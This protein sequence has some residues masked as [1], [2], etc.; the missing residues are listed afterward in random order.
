ML[1][2]SVPRLLSLLFFLL[3]TVVHTWPMASNPGTL[4]RN[5]N[6]DA[7]LNEWILAWVAHA[8]RTDPTALFHPPIFFPDRYAL[9][10]SENLLVPALLGAPLQWAGWSPILVH[11]LLFMGGF[12]LS[13]WTTSIVIERWTGDR[14]AA[15]LAG[16]A[17]AFNAHT[18][19]RLAH[20]QAQYFAFFPLALYAL[21]QLFREARARQAL[22]L[23]GWFVLQAYSS[24]YLLAFTSI[25]LVVA[26]VTRVD[27]LRQI[28][29]WGP[30][31]LLAGAAA[32][33]LCLPMLWPYQQAS[34][35]QQTTRPLAEVARFSATPQ[36]WL[37]TGGRLH[38][39]LWSRAFFW[40]DAL[41]PG[42]TVLLLG[43]VAVLRGPLRQDPRVRMVLAVT[44]TGVALSFGPALPGYTTLYHAFPLLGAIRGAARFGHLGLVGLALLAGFGLARV[45][46]GLAPGRVKTVISVMAVLLV[47][48]EALRAP[49]ILFPADRIDPIYDTLARPEVSG[50]VELPHPSV[51]FIHANA[52]YMLNATR[53]WRPLVN[54][55]SGLTPRTYR[56]TNATLAQFPDAASFELLRALRVSHVVLHTDALAPSMREAIDAR[57]DLRTYAESGP[58]RI[59]TLP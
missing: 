10:F 46:Q 55:Y 15:L 20:I 4:T 53:H 16:S 32:L 56:F 23:T 12:A 6:G 27:A 45:R 14:W 48:A 44:V 18:L 34:E 2:S 39:P 37:S 58:I 28:R 49:L 43:A 7:I 30:L 33:A 22:H 57:T 1:R 35:L 24:I 51:V 21:D 54:G 36:A 47:S 17:L 42:V 5:D 40:H 38:Y 19:T 52:Q 3:L 11:N 25:G 41:F 29:R 50:V 26:T 31:A 13:G 9:A 8:L 59:V